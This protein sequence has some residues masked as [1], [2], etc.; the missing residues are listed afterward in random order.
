MTFYFDN[1]G[2]QLAKVQKMLDFSREAQLAL[3]AIDN[4][5]VFDVSVCAEMPGFPVD[6]RGAIHRTILKYS[7]MGQP[8]NSPG[9]NFESLR[10]YVNSI[11]NLLSE[12]HS[13][14]HEVAM[15]R[16][17]NFSD[18][19]GTPLRVLC[20]RGELLREELVAGTYLERAEKG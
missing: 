1:K 7:V 19:P 13:I 12:L 9:L 2:E 18:D 10:D 17:T 4:T 15:W 3:E 11:G 5:V 6:L 16:L 8:A 14:F 20:A